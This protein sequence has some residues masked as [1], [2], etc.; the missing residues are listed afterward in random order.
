M[1][2][3]IITEVIVSKISGSI[4]ELVI[5][6]PIAR[7]VGAPLFFEFFNNTVKQGPDPEPTENKFVNIRYDEPKTSSD[8]DVGKGFKLYRGEHVTGIMLFDG[9]GKWRLYTTW[10]C[11]GLPLKALSPFP[12]SILI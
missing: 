1:C 5:A 10:N 6:N 4:R 2:Q 7:V 12:D 11:K 9:N 8:Y 3:V